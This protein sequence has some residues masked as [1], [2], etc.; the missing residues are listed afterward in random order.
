VLAEDAVVTSAVAPV[1][2]VIVAEGVRA[3][4]T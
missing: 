3:T 4:A 1:V 2:V